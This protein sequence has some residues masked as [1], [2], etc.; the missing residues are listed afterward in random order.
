MDIFDADLIS[1]WKSLN[2]FNV[3]YIM[4]GG[5]ALNLHGFSRSTN[6]ID[7]WLKDEVNNCANIQKSFKVDFSVFY[8]ANNLF[9]SIFVISLIA[10]AI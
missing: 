8:P 7:L 10:S 3:K 6:D 1:F 4:I 5:F 2:Q 9:T